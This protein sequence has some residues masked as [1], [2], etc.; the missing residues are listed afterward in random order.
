[1]RYCDQNTKTVVQARF[2]R[3]LESSSRMQWHLLF[4]LISSLLYVAGV[5]LIKRTSTTAVGVWRTTLISNLVTAASFL[6]LLP[7]GGQP[8]QWF[9]LWQPLL[10]ALLFIGGQTLTFL[11]LQHGDVS[12]ATPALGAKTIYVAWFSTLVLGEKVPWQL[13][14]AACLTFGAILLLNL[15]RHPIRHP[16][17]TIALALGSAACYACFDVL[18]QKWSP[19]W[20]VGRFL[21]VMFG[22]AALLSCAFLPLIQ[23]KW[24]DI[25]KEALPWLLGGTLFIALQALFL[26]TTVAVFGD[27]TAVN[28]VYSARGLWSVAT[29]WLVGHWFRNQ[30]QHLGSAVLRLRLLGAAFMTSAIVIALT[31]S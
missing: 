13:W 26:I 19:V 11:A 20:G 22:M 5:M 2:E 18:V 9:L 8:L 14:L 15:G 24:F 29:V 23:G 3:C 31:C 17:R 12:V 30:E 28:V 4:P 25:P 6:T 27:A 7:L 10:V 21:P 16:G 1:M